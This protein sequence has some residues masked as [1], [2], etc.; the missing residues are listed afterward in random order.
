VGRA[1]AHLRGTDLLIEPRKMWASGVAGLKGRIPVEQLSETGRALG[2]YGDGVW[3]PSVRR[4][5][6]EGGT[7]SPELVEASAALIQDRWKPD[8]AP[9]WVTCV[10]SAEGP[11]Q[12]PA[13]AEALAA[14]L[15]L[16]LQPVVTPARPHRPQSEMENSAQQLRNVHEAFAVAGALPSGPVLLVGDAVDSGWTLTVVGAALREAGSGPVHPFALAK[17]GA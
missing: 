3:G 4:A 16:P 10:P 2:M 11:E 8:P 9:E 1:L 17:T 6:T 15:G 7:F 12:V 5:R 13:F 14:R